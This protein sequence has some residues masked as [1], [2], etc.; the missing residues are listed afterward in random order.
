[1]T[2]RD[3]FGEERIHLA[4]MKLVCDPWESIYAQPSPVER[5]HSALALAL[6]DWRDLFVASDLANDDWTEVLRTAGYEGPTR[7]PDS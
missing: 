1:M 2:P 3:S 6:T 5:F 4:V 7:D